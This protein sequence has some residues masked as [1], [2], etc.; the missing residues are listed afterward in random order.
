MGLEAISPRPI[1]APARIGDLILDVLIE[2]TEN[3]T[4]RVTQFPVEDGS[5]VS[6]HVVNDPDTLTIVGMV[7]NSPIRS[8]GGPADGQARATIPV[9]DHVVGTALNFAELALAYLKQIRKNKTAVT[10]ITKRGRFENMIVQ[11]FRRTKDRNTGDALTFTVDLIAIR[12]VKLQFVAAPTRRTTS[13]RAQPRVDTG[14]KTAQ[15]AA[16]EN[17]LQS[18]FYSAG[19]GAKK[20]IVPLFK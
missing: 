14:K 20:Y 5:Q 10:V 18:T 4:N 8:H 1:V 7:T 19:Q 16:S 3:L 6:D 15:T 2:E 9:L 17:R 12:K 11:S 13:A